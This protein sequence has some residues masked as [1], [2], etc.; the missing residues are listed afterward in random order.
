MAEVARPTLKILM[1][2]IRTENLARVRASFEGAEEF[3]DYT[4]IVILD[5]DWARRHHVTL[6]ARTERRQL[7]VRADVPGQYG[8][9]NLNE[10]LKCVKPEDWVWFHADDNVTTP[11]FFPALRKEVDSGAEIVVFPMKHSAGHLQAKPS[12]MAPGHADQS[13]IA[14][15]A[16]LI[17]D[18]RWTDTWCP[19]GDWIAR[20]YERHA[21][22]FRYV[23]EPR[24]RYNDLR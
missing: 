24:L 8:E 3:F 21:D 22:K 12:S 11:D 17:G 9:R 15:K 14:L 13:Q 2:T 19:D 7:V 5:D 18:L 4:L 20:L 16:S 23:Q 6:E 10:G 1:P